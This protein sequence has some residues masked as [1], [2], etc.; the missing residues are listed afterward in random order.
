MKKTLNKWQVGV[1]VKRRMDRVDYMG[2]KQFQFYVLKFTSF[3]SMGSVVT[4]KHFKGFWI[5][6]MFWLPFDI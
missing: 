5:R 2:W 3:P 1:K 6:F 4:K